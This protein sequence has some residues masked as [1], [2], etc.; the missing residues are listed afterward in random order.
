MI[1]H[2]YLCVI[3]YYNVIVYH[4]LSVNKCSCNATK[5]TGSQAVGRT[6][7]LREGQ[8]DHKCQTNCLNNFLMKNYMRLS[9]VQTTDARCIIRGNKLSLK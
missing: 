9:L 6:F 3:F 7:E 8:H 4:K 1:D 2:R 5:S